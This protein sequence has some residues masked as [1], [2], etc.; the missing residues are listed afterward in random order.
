MAEG[1]SGRSAMVDHNL[2]ARLWA[3]AAL[4]SA[5][6]PASGRLGWWLPLHIVLAG[7]VSQSIVGGQQMF[8]ST[9]GMAPALPTVVVRAQLALMNLGAI[10]VIVGRASSAEAL[11]GAGAVTFLGGAMW[12][13]ITARRAW[14]KGLG[15]RFAMTRTYYSLAVVSLLFGATL[16]AALGLGW[17]T[18]AGGYLSHRSAHMAFN[19]MGWVG[20]TILGTI[21]T[22]LPMLL[23][24]RAPSSRRLGAPPWAYGASL[25]VMTSGLMVQSRGVAVAGAV[26]MIAVLVPFVAM[27]KELL[28][29]HRRRRV[30][31][32]AL[33]VMSALGW[34]GVVLVTQPFLLA[35]GELGVLR[36]M[37][38]VAMALGTAAQAVLGAW[39]FLVP[40]ARPAEPGLRRRELVAFEIGAKPQVVIY[41]L[42]LVALFAE[43]RGW[44]PGTVGA[45][46]LGMVLAAAAW[47]VFKAWA[48]RWIAGW[49]SMVERTARWW[50]ALDEQA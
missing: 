30:P 8:S 11:L 16:G 36:D 2:S 45:A 39:A 32:S 48:F 17:I 20:L 28:G 35:A 44:A 24:V 18:S 9:L 40:M 29:R 1:L 15:S 19:L 47:G 22:F 23:R 27:M 50:V 42:G 31:V 5:L 41:N 13:G 37:Y 21:V 4:I 46:G 7:V 3:V 26:G 25:L 43:L 38:V 10:G 12:G 6:V 49:P 34:F 14:T 33:H